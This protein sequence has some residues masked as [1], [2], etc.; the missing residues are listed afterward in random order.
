MKLGKVVVVGGS[1]MVGRELLKVMSSHRFE[2]LE[3]VITGFSTVG[4]TIHSPFGDLMV[5]RLEQEI[6]SGAGLIF[7][8]AGAPISKEWIP[9]VRGLFGRVIDLSSAFRYKPDVPLVIPSINGDKI[10]GATL[11]ACPNC[12]TSIALMALAPIHQAY[13]I[14]RVSM[15]SYQSVS[16]AGKEALDALERQ[17]REWA[18]SGSPSRQGKTGKTP[19]PLAGNLFARIDSLDPAWG[20]FTREEMKTHWESNKILF[21]KDGGAVVPCVSTCIRVPIRRCHSEVLT[22]QVAKPAT[23]TGIKHILQGAFGVVVLDFPVE[24]IYP[25]PLGMEDKEEVGVGRIRLSPDSEGKEI[26]LWVCGDQ[27]LRGAALTAVEIAEYILR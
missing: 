1:G 22:I 13:G 15:A 4:D 3:L 19:Y 24:D 20:G 16:G 12:T 17:T 25:T 2:P 11:V 23:V 14:T 10:N 18:K 7:F 6:F 26:V 9:K 8:A 5:K 21:Q 27:L